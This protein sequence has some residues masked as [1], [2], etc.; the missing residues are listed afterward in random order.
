MRD[1]SKAT[2]RGA[3]GTAVLGS[4]VALVLAS[5]AAFPSSIYVRDCPERSYDLHPELFGFATGFLTGSMVAG[6]SAMASYGTKGRALAMTVVLASLIVTGTHGAWWRLALTTRGLQPWF[7]LEW[8]ETAS[9]IKT[10]V[11]VLGTAAGLAVAACIYLVAR[12]SH[13]RLSWRLGLAMACVLF[14]TGTWVIP[15]LVGHVT[16]MAQRG[17]WNE[18][19]LGDIATVRGSA[20]GSA[21]GSLIG[22]VAC[23]LIG[24]KR[25]LRPLER[26]ETLA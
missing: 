5:P 7:S 20:V 3:I 14:T 23:V 17:Y 11:V 6:A 19:G 15:W 16:D 9:G 1:V 4:A 13:W 21:T 18:P 10:G 22:A 12:L 24:R 2:V 26:M 8:K 25:P